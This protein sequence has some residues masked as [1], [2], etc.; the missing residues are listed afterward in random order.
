MQGNI[1][2]PDVEKRGVVFDPRTKMLI[3]ITLAIFVLGG[4]GGEK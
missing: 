3:L 1:L 2:Q 4:S